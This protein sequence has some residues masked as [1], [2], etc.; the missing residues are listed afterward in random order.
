MNPFHE[1]IIR[2]LEPER[3][4]QAIAYRQ[5]IE[6]REQRERDLTSEVTINCADA[7]SAIG[8]AVRAPRV[9]V[10]DIEAAIKHLHAAL[11]AARELDQ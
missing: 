10:T 1:A 7:I 5:Q 11:A 4:A 6:Q 8:S 2:L 3:P 9:A